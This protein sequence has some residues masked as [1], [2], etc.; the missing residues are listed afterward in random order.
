MHMLSPRCLPRTLKGVGGARLIDMPGVTY[1]ESVLTGRKGID[2]RSG[3][4]HARPPEW[5]ISTREAAEM[6]GISTRATRALLNR[7]NSEYR[8]VACPGGGACMYWDRR[9]VERE[10]D[11]RIPLVRKQPEKLCSASEAC[12]ILLVARSSLSRY[13]QRGLLKEHRIRL[14]TPT[15]VRVLSCFLRSEVRNLAARKEAARARE[16]EVRRERLKRNWNGRIGGGEVDLD[17][18]NS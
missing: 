5:G 15:G 17:S 12:Y 8:L 18:A 14:A 1:P 2:Q 16:E 13:V 3:K 6:L 9:V 10:L 4:P 11:N 7:L